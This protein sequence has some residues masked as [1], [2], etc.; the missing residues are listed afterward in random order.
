MPPGRRSQRASGPFPLYTC[1]PPIIVIILSSIT[2]KKKSTTRPTLPST[3]SISTTKKYFLCLNLAQR[4]ISETREGKTSLNSSANHHLQVNKTRMQQAEVSLLAFLIYFGN[5]LC[6]KMYSSRSFFISLFLSFL[7]VSFRVARASAHCCVEQEF[8][9][10][11]D[12]YRTI[13]V[14][15]TCEGS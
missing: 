7:L 3:E 15:A 11:Y 10:F 4:N 13:Q 14:S 2:P 6:T 8:F 9:A 12:F 1:F 5:Q